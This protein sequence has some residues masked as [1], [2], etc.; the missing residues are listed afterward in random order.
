MWEY[1][2]VF[3][4]IYMYFVKYFLKKIPHIST[5]F[6]TVGKIIQKP[7]RIQIFVLSADRSHHC[8]HGFLYGGSLYMQTDLNTRTCGVVPLAYMAL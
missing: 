3:Q 7:D 2:K 4:K 6:L 8:T 1:K 5:S